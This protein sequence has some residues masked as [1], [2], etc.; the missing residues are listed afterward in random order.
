ML[1]LAQEASLFFGIE[2]EEEDRKLIEY[3]LKV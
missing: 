2:S 1:L 3:V